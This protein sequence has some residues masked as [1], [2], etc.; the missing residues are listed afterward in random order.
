MCYALL[1]RVG[2]GRLRGLVAAVVYA[3]AQEVVYYSR[4]LWPNMFPCMLLLILWSLLALRE[5]R[6]YHLALLGIWLG[7]ALQL[8]PTGVL[9]APFL[10]LYVV[11]FRPRLHSWRHALRGLLA[12]LLLCAPAIIHDATHGLVETKAWLTDRH[13]GTPH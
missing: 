2:C 7:V 10:A 3:T 6:Q 12:F 9:L 5:G 8:Q 1:V 11:L 13:G 4:F